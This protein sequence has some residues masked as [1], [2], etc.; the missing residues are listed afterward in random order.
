MPPA[1]STESQGLKIATIALSVLSFFLAITTYFGFS[2]YSTAEEKAKKA[3][4]S[5]SEAQRNLGE[6]NRALDYLLTTT[7]DKVGGKDEES[8]KRA[9]EQHRAKLANNIK[10]VANEVGKAV[11]EVQARGGDRAL[12]DVLK[13][14]VR[15]AD[16]IVNE[17]NQTLMSSNNR[18]ADLLKSHSML[19]TAMA[20][21]NLGM[22]NQ[23]ENVNRVNDEKVQAAENAADKANEDLRTQI[24]RN[25]DARKTDLAKYEETSTRNRELATQVSQ[26]ET[27]IALKTDQYTREKTDMLR[28]QID[29]KDRLAKQ[30]TVLDVADGKVTLI[31]YTRK[32]I[33][34]DLTRRQGLK[35]QMKLAIFDRAAPGIPTD[36]PKAMVEVIQVGETDSVAR[37]LT[38]ANEFDRN[39]MIENP[40]YVGDQ[41]YSSVWSPN[42]PRRFA[43]VG[44]IDMNRDGQDDRADLKRLIEQAGGIV[45]YDLPPPN[46]GRETGK[47]SGRFANYVIDERPPVFAEQAR[48]DTSPEYTAFEER[49]RE[50]IKAFREEGVTPIPVERL[51]PLLGYSFGMSQPGR[52][53]AYSRE[54]FD[55]LRFP[56]GRGRAAATNGVSDVESPSPGFE[57]PMEEP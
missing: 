41:V 24:Q 53:E 55:R 12:D 26:L 37:I 34:M 1:T 17:P 56:Q 25:E 35:P 29:L 20:I 28:Q 46:A 4:Q 49:K 13:M 52:P 9:V 48:E 3:E 47:P 18:M 42:D 8:I 2:N 16:S 11:S 14:A 19:T 22:R 32:E 43:L 27:D 31:D 7:L 50:V 23:L 10:A 33:R 21:D 6:A 40:I 51:L 30:D 15:T 36:R 38:P 44:K 39:Y 54:I 57:A 5:A 45:E